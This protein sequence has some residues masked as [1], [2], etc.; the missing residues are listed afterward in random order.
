VS[1]H[2]TIFQGDKARKN[3]CY[4][5]VV[6]G[7]H[8]LYI[9]VDDNKQSLTVFGWFTLQTNGSRVKSATLGLGT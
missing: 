9:A 8:Y 1:V 5:K 6:L 2:Q 3:F 7:C 4:N